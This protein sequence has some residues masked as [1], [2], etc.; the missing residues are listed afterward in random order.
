MGAGQGRGR[1]VAAVTYRIEWR[2]RARKAFLAL[3]KPVRRGIG[4]ALAADPRPVEPCRP[5]ECCQ[6]SYGPAGNVLALAG[7][8]FSTVWV[9]EPSLPVDFSL[10]AV[11]RGPRFP[12][13]I[14]HGINHSVT[15]A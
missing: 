9:A 3:D 10:P 12:V 1:A 7:Q 15:V 2:S 14:V 5:E 4:E 6:V 13:G 8:V 11:D